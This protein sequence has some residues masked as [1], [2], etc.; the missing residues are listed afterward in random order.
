[1]LK[2]KGSWRFEPPEDGNYYNKTIP[3]DAVE[4]FIDIVMRLSTQGERRK[5][6]E[7]FKGYFCKA[8]G[9]T[10]VWS[11]T[12]SWAETDLIDYMRRAAGNA[13]LFIEALYD[14]GIALQENYPDYVTV[15]AKLI[16]QILHKHNVGYEVS[17]PDLLIREKSS[18]VIEVAERPP[19][20]EEK[21]IDLYQKSLQ[22]S[23]ELISKG[24]GRE[25]VQ[26]ILWLLE[27]VT[28]TFRGL[29]T[30]T[31]VIEGKYFNKIAQELKKANRGKSIERIMDWLTS[32]YGYLSSP[33]GG[34][35]RHGI[36]L[37]QPREMDVHEAR[38]YCNLIRSYL[39]FIISEHE[40]LSRHQ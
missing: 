19:T 9:T 22:R 31:H 27:S 39:E 38:L 33:T 35:V 2:F 7:H 12:E 32:L 3:D 24:Q 37:N 21:A 6:I 4:E 8:V 23:E 17:P 40:R 11:T 34:G 16:N 30:G 15:D 10:H 25:A 5:I 29:E 28:T 20:L 18:S 26:E 13:P 1:M 14:A 36:D